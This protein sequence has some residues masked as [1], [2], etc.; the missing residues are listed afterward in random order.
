M[1]CKTNPTKQDLSE[2]KDFKS[3]ILEYATPKSQGMSS[4]TLLKMLQFVKKEK[5]NINS[6]VIA[7][8]ENQKISDFFQNT[9]NY[10]IA[11][12]KSNL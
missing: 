11:N 4:E 1:S 7:K 6:L 12:R 9:K 2:N 3:S 8:N 5:I 10:L